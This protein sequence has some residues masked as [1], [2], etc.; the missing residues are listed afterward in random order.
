MNSLDLVDDLEGLRSALLQL[1]LLGLLLQEVG[2]VSVGLGT[3]KKRGKCKI[4]KIIPSTTVD[5]YIKYII[6][7]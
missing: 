1:S 5:S 4:T 6:G 2:H 7:L 3:G